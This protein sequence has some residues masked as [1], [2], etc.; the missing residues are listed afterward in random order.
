MTSSFPVFLARYSS[1][2]GDFLLEQVRARTGDDDHRGVSR[3]LVGLR[4]HQL[5]EL[6]VV[7]LQRVADPAV[8]R[9]GLSSLGPSRRVHSGSRPSAAVDSAA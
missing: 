9:I 7:A 8:I 3:D 2:I 6:I 5:V 1:R 4:Q